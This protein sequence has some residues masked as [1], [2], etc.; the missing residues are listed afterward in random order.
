MKLF[1]DDE[2]TPG[3]VYPGVPDW[4]LVSTYRAAVLMLQTGWIQELSLD[5]DLGMGEPTGYE[6]AC[7]LE[8]LVLSGAIPMPKRMVCHSANPAGR[9]RIEST[10]DA[11]IRHE[12]FLSEEVSNET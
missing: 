12:K 4:I 9:K 5:H 6:I 11:T 2:R 7:K 8:R 10:F 1:V 3:F